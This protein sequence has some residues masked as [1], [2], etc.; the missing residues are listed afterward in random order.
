MKLRTLLKKG[1]NIK[2]LYADTKMVSK[3][4]N[5][6]NIL[7]QSHQPFFLA[8]GFL[9]PHLPFSKRILGYI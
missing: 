6:L 1:E 9:K 4:I 8:V 7:N 2:D 5:E 3:A